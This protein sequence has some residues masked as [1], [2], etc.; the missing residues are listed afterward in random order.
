MDRKRVRKILSTYWLILV[1][2]LVLLLRLPSLSEPFT[3]GDE[4]IYL[5][6]GQALR[7]GLVFYR[8]IHDNKPPMLYLLAA[9][10]GSFTRFRVLL[11]FWASLTIFIF[12]ELCLLLF[13]KN[14]KAIVVATTTFA[15]LTS[16]HTFE[17]NVANAEN[18]MLLPILTGFYLFLKNNSRKISWSV[19]LL[20]GYLFSFATLF[21]VPAAFD[22]AALF[23]LAVLISKSHTILK[24]LFLLITGF[25]LPISL[26]LIYYAAKGSFQQYLTAAFLQ[27]I[28]YLS[29]WSLDKPQTVG[30]PLAFIGRGSS[31]L[32]V[33]ALLFIYRKNISTQIQLI[34][35]WF[36]FA[37]FA[38][39]LSSRPYPHY[40]LQVIPALSLSF[41]LLFFKGKQKIIPIILS[42]SLIAVF[43]IFKFWHYPNLSYYQN[44]YQHLL[45]MK[46]KE[47]YFADFG[48]HT[49]AI[50][51]IAEYLRTHTQPD[52]KIFIWGN[53]PSIYALAN[54][55][56]VGRYTVAYH[57][58]D[59]DGFEETINL[60]SEN[61]PRYIITE[62]NLPFPSLEALLQADYTLELQADRLSL[63]HRI[64]R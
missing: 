22:F 37:L 21:K 16:I 17:G 34:V 29:S 4:G 59:F 53:Q 27:N 8:D 39:L 40:L 18:F 54:R 13:P 38:S 11:F 36:S 45:K 25:L 6:L 52:E 58:Q 19:W 14:K 20:I 49:M 61:P 15:I 2:G 32:A 7:K 9:L 50:Y 3:Y 43:L 12:Y 33:I 46:T 1:L 47:E 64:L 44:F 60:L 48:S 10:A 62:K 63:F 23:I 30:L 41:G 28:P 24:N 42:V 26:T 57:I 56:P 51:Q 55:L 5:T 31:V 35:L